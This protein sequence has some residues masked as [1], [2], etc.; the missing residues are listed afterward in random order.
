MDKFLIG[1]WVCFLGTLLFFYIFM[2]ALL[3]PDRLHIL[4][5]ENEDEDQHL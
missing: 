5:H 4:H 1:F 3:D 2:L